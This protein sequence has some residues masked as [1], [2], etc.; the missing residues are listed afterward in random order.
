MPGPIGIPG[1]PGRAVKGDIGPQ[2]PPGPPGQ[3]GTSSSN[4]NW[5]NITISPLPID[6]LLKH[7]NDT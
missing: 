5:I 3:L 6:V 4:D 2:G 7:R 1:P